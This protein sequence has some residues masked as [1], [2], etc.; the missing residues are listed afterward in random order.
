M[1]AIEAQYQRLKAKFEA[2]GDERKRMR[3]T[4]AD[5]LPTK[6]Y[7]GFCL[8][9]DDIRKQATA[10]RASNGKWDGITC[11][12]VEN[13]EI[14]DISVRAADGQSI[15]IPPPAR[16]FGHVIHIP[17]FG[18][19]FLAELTVNHNS[20]HLTMIR[21]DMGCLAAGSASLATCNV[22]GRGSGG[23]GGT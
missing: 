17:D 12:L 23:S 6:K 1:K 5:G 15:Q 3:L 22:N 20:Y 2:L 13:V 8:D 16:S 18:N 11:S 4:E 21:V 9:Y 14:K 7:H 19:I 10:A